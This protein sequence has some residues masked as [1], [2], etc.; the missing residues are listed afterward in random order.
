MGLPDEYPVLAG[1]IDPTHGVVHVVDLGAPADMFAMT[2]VDGALIHADRQGALI[3]PL[4]VISGLVDA[5]ATL[6][7]SERIILEAVRDKRI[8]FEQFKSVWA[9]F[10]AARP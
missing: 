8:F 9:A 1:S 10:E 2:V 3:I 5:I 7:K 4:N 6:I